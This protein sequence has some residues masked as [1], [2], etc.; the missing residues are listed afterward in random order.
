MNASA[1]QMPIIAPS[2]QS[3]KR[4]GGCVPPG[5]QTVDA[6]AACERGI[7]P[8]ETIWR[9]KHKVVIAPYRLRYEIRPVCGDC[10]RKGGTYT[11]G[12]ETL[13]YSGPPWEP[14]KP[15]DHCGRSVV[16]LQ[17]GRWRRHTFCAG[18]C[19]TAYYNTR[20]R[21]R[22]NPAHRKLCVGCC[23]EFTATRRNVKTCSSACRQR[24]YRTRKQEAV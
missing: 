22:R 15:C 3:L 5:R 8:G 6:C 23:K 24:A 16:N 11:I 20:A 14:A 2:Q 19:Q 13:W 7:G 1:L 17:T 4:N 10:R 18:K 9:D 21:E 12:G